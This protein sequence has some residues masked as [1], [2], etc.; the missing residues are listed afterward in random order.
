MNSSLL[1]LRMSTANTIYL[2]C[3][4][5]LWPVEPCICHYIMRFAWIDYNDYTR[6]VCIEWNKG[7]SPVIHMCVCGLLH[8]V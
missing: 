6:N 7:N 4:S 2:S 3:G 8:S 1:S 5:C